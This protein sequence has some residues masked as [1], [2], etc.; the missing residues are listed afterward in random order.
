MVV[1]RTPS[2]SS[3]VVGR[4]SYGAH[5]RAQRPRPGGRWVRLL[6]PPH[7]A[8]YVQL[9]SFTT[10]SSQLPASSEQLLYTHPL[11]GN[12]RGMRTSLHPVREL[13]FSAHGASRL[14]I[15][16]CGHAMHATCYDSFFSAQL[17]RS[18]NQMVN[19][20][21]ACDP[22]RRE[23]QCPLCK[24]LMNCL[25]PLSDEPYSIFPT[26]R[27]M[28]LLSDRTTW[29]NQLECMHARQQLY[30]R[31]PLYQNLAD[32]C[33]YLRYAP[34]QVRFMSDSAFMD[35]LPTDLRAVARHP[36]VRTSMGLYCTASAI[37]ATLVATSHHLLRGAMEWKDVDRLC[38][39]ESLQLLCRSPQECYGITDPISGESLAPALRDAFLNW[40]FPSQRPSKCVYDMNGVA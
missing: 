5:L 27:S 19:R 22:T 6:S 39:K 8:G 30:P 4:Y 20:V 16:T 12:C 3:A 9:Y 37:G 33:L 21:S 23:A 32:I 29:A 38:L 7:E 18:L 34:R 10:L 26:T 14:H 15:S 24:G 25:L 36:F 40:F 13:C 2:T 1:Y 31:N 28:S 35:T 11:D 17:A